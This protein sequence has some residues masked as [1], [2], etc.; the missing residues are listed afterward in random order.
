MTCAAP[1]ALESGVKLP[2]R[3]Y[4]HK[5]PRRMAIFHFK[6]TGIEPLLSTSFQ[7]MKLL[8]RN[9]LQRLLRDRLDVIAPDAMLLTEE[10][11]QWE[12]A[13]R[14]IDLLAL[15]RDA[16]LVVIELKRTEDAG[17]IELQALRYAAM[18]ST[19]TFE[20]A[21]DAHAAY[22][23]KVNRDDD[24]RVAI[25]D[26]LGWTESTEG[27]FA[28]DVRIVLVASD[29]Q[30]EITTAVL[31]LNERKL[32][33]RCVRMQPY[34]FNGEVLVDVQQVIPLPE[35]AEY[36]IRVREREEQRRVTAAM[37]GE[38]DHT[39]FDV[40]VQ[41]QIHRALNKRR[42]ILTVVQ[43]LAKAGISPESMS[44]AVPSRGDRFIISAV[45]KLDSLSFI[46]TVTNDRVAQ[47]RTFDP[48]RWFYSDEEL[49]HFDGRTYAVS[50]QWGTGTEQTLRDLTSQFPQAKIVIEAHDS[51][52]VVG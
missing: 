23:R 6:P 47:N 15:D 40:T 13:R 5:L 35:A 20:Q 49:V 34:T 37:T 33:I 28:A 38:R 14:R 45:G 9:D 25:L 31:W 50:N 22:L 12:D 21:V 7:S 16:K 2:F 10:F 32:D 43:A 52:S 24:A 48:A 46:E 29:F 1:A 17:H 42:A 36:Q 18:V 4:R 30:K 3:L 11:G 27:E 44:R 41:G 51:S 39:K 19:M 26:F 8:E